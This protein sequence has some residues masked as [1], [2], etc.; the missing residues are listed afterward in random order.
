MLYLIGTPGGTL[1]ASCGV[2][3]G[4]GA[5]TVVV[6]NL[7]LLV[8]GVQLRDGVTTVTD[9]LGKMFVR[10]GLHI[11]AMEKG[12]ASTIYGAHQYDPVVIS[13]TPPLSYGDDRSDILVALEFD[14]NPDAPVQPNRDTILRH[15]DNLKDGGV[16]LYDR[17]TGPGETRGL[18]A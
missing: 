5:E 16:L 18:E 1:P 8:G 12:Y 11:L 6:N 3:S 2:T 4:E 13:A 9:I 14:T 17:S 15:G 7:K 10:A